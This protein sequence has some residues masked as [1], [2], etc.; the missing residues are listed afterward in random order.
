M[1]VA[2]IL[3]VSNDTVAGSAQLISSIR[4]QLTSYGTQTQHGTDRLDSSALSPRSAC[5]GL[6]LGTNE[7]VVVPIIIRGP[8]ELPPS[9][10]ALKFV[11]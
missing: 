3:L 2:K 9:L 10:A 8:T 5:Q 6:R 4:T 1:I 11:F 7:S